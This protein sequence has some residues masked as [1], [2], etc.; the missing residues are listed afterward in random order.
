MKVVLNT[1]IPPSFSR[2]QTGVAQLVE[3]WSPKPKVASSILA[4]RAKQNIYLWQV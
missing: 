3:Q 2:L 1:Q 4:A